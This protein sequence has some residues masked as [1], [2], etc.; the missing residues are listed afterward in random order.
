MK[1]K[2]SETSTRRIRLLT[3]LTASAAG[4][5][6]LSIAG[7]PTSDAVDEERDVVQIVRT[8]LG[9]P[10][11]PGDQELDAPP[12][13]VLALG[14]IRDVVDLQLGDPDVQEEFKGD[15]GDM[16]VP[17]TDGVKGDMGD[18][19]DPGEPGQPGNPGDPGDD[20]DDGLACWDLNG[21]GVPDI[22]T[23]DTN[24]DGVVDVNDCAGDDGSEG[25]DGLACWDLNGNGVP[26]IATEDTNNDGVVNV[27]DCK[28][29][30]G[31]DITDHGQLDGLGDDDHPQYVFNGEANTVTTQMIVNASVTLPKISTDGADTGQVMKYNGSDLV[32]AD[33][34]TNGGNSPWQQSG[35]GIWY[36]GQPLR[37]GIGTS[38][39]GHALDVR[40]NVRLGESQNHRIDI[41]GTVRLYAEDFKMRNAADTHDAVRLTGDSRIIL[42][43]PNTGN[44]AV[45]ITHSGN[46]VQCWNDGNDITVKLRGQGPGDA[47]ALYLYDANG[48]ESIVLRADDGSACKPGGGSWTS[49]SDL[50]LKKNVRSL[51]GALD[52]LLAL[53]GVTFEF[54]DPESINELTGIR[55]GM[56]AQEVEKVFPDWIHEESDGYKRL[57]F[58]GFEAL[59]VEALRELRAEKDARI[60][61]QQEQIDRMEARLK[62]LEAA[63]KQR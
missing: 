57:T 33:D 16:G 45:L 50:R 42:N 20:G 9:V 35:N 56:I 1:C 12:S 5:G 15:M 29:A 26:D 48:N 21:N 52:K 4:M 34:A 39:P 30:A 13:D 23:E 47:G 28:G 60:A 10:P 46:K 54:K 27:L 7:C 25:D 3:V 6:L 22:A 36:D 24:G 63:I 40:G 19:G 44:E 62:R 14:E 43:D 2:A 49:C 41:E 51:D 37:V 55:T 17:G 31:G 38:T 58:R 18:Q 59:A 32:W 8:M 61:A 53:R 11:Q